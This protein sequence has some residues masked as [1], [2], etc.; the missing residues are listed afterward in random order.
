[1][2][3]V[4]F[5]ALP[6][7]SLLDK[8]C[9]WNKKLCYGKNIWLSGGIIKVFGRTGRVLQ[10][11]KLKTGVDCLGMRGQGSVLCYDLV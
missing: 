1:M 10:D 2:R 3:P 4:N 6:V 7:V 5:I 9:I 8:F 11:V